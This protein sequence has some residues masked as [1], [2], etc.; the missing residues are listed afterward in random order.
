MEHKVNHA[1]FYIPERNNIRMVQTII[2]IQWT[3]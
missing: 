3:K 2:S 1:S